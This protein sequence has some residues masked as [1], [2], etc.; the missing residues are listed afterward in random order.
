MECFKEDRCFTKN[1]KSKLHKIVIKFMNKFL[2]KILTQ[3]TFN[4][5]EFFVWYYKPH[6]RPGSSF[7]WMF[8]Q[9]KKM[10]YDYINIMNYLLNTISRYQIKKILFWDYAWLYHQT[11][12]NVEVKPKEISLPKAMLDFVYLSY[13]KSI[14]IIKWALYKYGNMNR[15]T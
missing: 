5:N 4:T 11:I 10:Y 14:S 3:I 9:C 7:A 15:K 1:H 12:L 8:F 2:R 6:F 13:Q